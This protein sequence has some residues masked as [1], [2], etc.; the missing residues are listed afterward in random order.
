MC[1]K[2]NIIKPNIID[3][4]VNFDL[5]LAILG[6]TPFRYILRIEKIHNC[7]KDVPNKKASKS[8]DIDAFLTNIIFLIKKAD[9]INKLATPHKKISLLE[10]FL[11]IK[12]N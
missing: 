6:C 7:T 10:L 12:F 11:I 8:L 4:K 1:K 3:K 9:T 2:I 5:Y